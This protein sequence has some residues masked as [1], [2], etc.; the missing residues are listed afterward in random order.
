MHEVD[1]RFCRCGHLS[2]DD[3]EH[4]TQLLRVGWFPASQDR[5]QTAF[6]FVALDLFHEL[7][8]QGKI[9]AHDYY[10]GTVHLTD[11]TGTVW[12]NVSPAPAHIWRHKVTRIY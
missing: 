11:N 2:Y 5:P 4:R 10:Y 1:V 7:S 3:R 9:S 6:T 8:V 12:V